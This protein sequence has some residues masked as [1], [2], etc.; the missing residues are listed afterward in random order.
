M[1]FSDSNEQLDV[2]KC[3]EFAERISEYFPMKVLPTEKN[4]RQLSGSEG[5]CKDTFEGEVTLSKIAKIVTKEEDASFPAAYQ[6][7]CNIPSD[8]LEFIL[9]LCLSDP[10]FPAFVEEVEDK[11]NKIK[12]I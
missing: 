10:T 12:D 4:C 7:C 5:R 11:L 8:K 6:K 9:R 3:R 2:E 1:Q